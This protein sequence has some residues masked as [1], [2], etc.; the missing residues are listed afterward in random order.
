MLL[1]QKIE[2]KTCCTVSN[3]FLK[4]NLGE[5]GTYFVDP[6]DQVTGPMKFE[7]LKPHAEVHGVYRF[8]RIPG[9]DKDYYLERH[10]KTIFN[11]EG[12]FVQSTIS[13]KKAFYLIN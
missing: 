2:F 6:G 4:V 5:I 1:F 13:R 8:R 10:R 12:N 11:A 3:Y 9:T 7:I